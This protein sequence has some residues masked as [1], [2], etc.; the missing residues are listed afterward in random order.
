MAEDPCQ[1]RDR[2]IEYFAEAKG[3]V[4]RLLGAGHVGNSLAFSAFASRACH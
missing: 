1:A 4:R 2:W 3:G